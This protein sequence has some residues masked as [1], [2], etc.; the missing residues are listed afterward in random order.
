M[1][2]CWAWGFSSFLECPSCGLRQGRCDEAGS[3]YVR[4]LDILE[5]VKGGIYYVDLAGILNNWAS[6]LWEQV[7]A[8]ASPLIVRDLL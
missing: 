4:A 7:S 3:E 5:N 1:L 8:G 6:L 2:G